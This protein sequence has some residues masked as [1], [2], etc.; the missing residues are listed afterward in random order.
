MT[1][2]LLDRRD[3]DYVRDNL[4]FNYCL[5][6]E[7]EL[8]IESYVHNNG[9]RLGFNPQRFY[10]LMTGVHKKF[11]APFTPATF[12]NGV[13]DIYASYEAIGNVLQEN[14]YT[15]RA[16]QIKQ[17][18]SKQVGVLFSPCE[19][20]K[21]PPDQMA[22]KIFDAYCQLWRSSNHFSLDYI[23]TSFVGPYS[24]YEQIH[25]AFLDAR[26]LNDLIF[27]GVR[28]IVIT[29]EYRAKTARPCDIPAIHANVR[30]LITTICTGT[31][32][33]AL[34]Q[35]DSIIHRMIAPSY[36]MD[37]F[38]AMFIA[39]D[40][41]L[42]MLE[43]VYPNHIR[44]TRRAYETFFTLE[45]YRAWLREIIRSIFE[46]LNGVSRY[47][48]TI[49]MALSYINR[50][51][52]RDLSLTQLSEYVYANASTLSS[53]FNTA[54][55]MSLSEYI[56]G[57]RVGKARELLRETDLTVPEIAEQTG[58]SSAKY[59]REIFKRQTGLSPQACRNGRN[60]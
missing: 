36:A 45:D 21:I 5:G 27:F 60:D 19:D 26:E 14:G 15:G 28:D 17:D 49:L 32:A 43:T 41:L 29:K 9:I 13:S 46:Q 56:T 12:Y 22:Q 20:E 54:V 4:I 38:T 57:L 42:G 25:Q 35:A 37:N 55:G 18:N 3:T 50:N 59:F 6:N 52:A 10:F 7:Q 48:P 2:Q 47:S 23:S 33:Q 31:C 8:L 30:R 24:G 34:R 1:E 11:T 51:Y 53:E 16:F 39:C 58:F 44:I 40:D